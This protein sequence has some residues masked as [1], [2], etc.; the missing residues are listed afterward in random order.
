MNTEQLTLGQA[1][2]NRRGA[3][4]MRN[5]VHALCCAHAH[6]DNRVSGM[7]ARYKNVPKFLYRVPVARVPMNNDDERKERETPHT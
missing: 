4:S 3:R 5:P 1:L 7:R 2:S 6:R